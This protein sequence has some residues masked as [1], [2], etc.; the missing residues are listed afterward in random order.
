MIIPTR[1]HPH[2]LSPIG[3]KGAGVRAHALAALDYPRERF[4]VIVVNDGDPAPAGQTAEAFRDCLHVTVLTQAHAGP[5]AARNLGAAHAQGRYLAFLDDDC[6][7]EAGWLAAFA[8]RLSA[9]PFHLVGGQTLN[10]LPDN[11]YAT[12]TH[13]L[14]GFLAQSHRCVSPHRLFLPS[15]N[16][17]LATDRFNAVGGFDPDFTLAAGED[18]DF[19]NRWAERG[20][21]LAYVPA[22]VAYH[23]HPLTL[24]AFVRQHFNYG[25]GAFQVNAKRARRTGG[26]VQLEPLSFYRRLV[27]CAA[28]QPLTWRLTLLLL[29]SQ[30]ATGAGFVRQMAADR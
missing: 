27:T 5:A 6:I 13:L 24:R 21:P 4:E 30:A 1:P 7:P 11:P 28:G 26:R 10:A 20:W 9:T 29:L 3:E 25:R 12:A 15:N 19:C 18:R 8:T 2:P 22:A 16:L 23:A 17:A 14:V